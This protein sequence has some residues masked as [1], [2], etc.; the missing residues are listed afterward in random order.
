MEWSAGKGGHSWGWHWSISAGFYPLGKEEP[1]KSASLGP[2]AEALLA[3]LGRKRQ[4]GA[5][6]WSCNGGIWEVC[7]S[8][9]LGRELLPAKEAQTFSIPMLIRGFTGEDEGVWPGEQQELAPQPQWGSAPWAKQDGAE[10]VLVK[11]GRTPR[12]W[13]PCCDPQQ[14]EK[15]LAAEQW[16][17]LAG[18]TR[19]LS[20]T[21]ETMD[22]FRPFW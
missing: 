4:P 5:P 8:Q 7:V 6:Y 18:P 19:Q 12:R 15:W 1:G 9:P 22:H 14:G 3:V 17:G 16:V 20:S 13:D 10:V 2:K 21:A 11:E